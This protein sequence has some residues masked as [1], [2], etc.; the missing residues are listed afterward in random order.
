MTKKI[1]KILI[2]IIISL[3]IGTNITISNTIA[4]TKVLAATTEKILSSKITEDTILENEHIPYLVEDDITIPKNITLTINEGVKLKFAPNTKMNIYGTLIINGSSQSH[5]TFTSQTDEKWDKL[6]INS[7]LNTINYLDINNA[8]DGI[9][10]LNNEQPN[11]ITNI[12]MTN[13]IYNYDF[14]N[15]NYIFFKNSIL[16]AT[17]TLTS[18]YDVNKDNSIDILDISYLANSYNLKSGQNGF[19]QSKDFNKDNIIDIYDLILLSKNVGA[20]SSKLYGYTVFIDPGHG[21]SD[22][23]AVQNGYK[24]KTI[25]LSLAQKLKA[26]LLKYG[27]DVVMS[28][29][30]DIAVSLDDRTTMATNS[31]ADL[32]ISIHHNSSESSSPTGIT[33]YYSTYRPGIEISG[34]YAIYNGKK[35]PYISEGGG[36]FTINYNGKSKWVNYNTEDITVYDSTPSN[37]AIDSKA[38]STLMVNSI[39]SL[40]FKNDGSI[41]SNLR[42]TRWTTMPSILLEAGFISNA[43][44]AAKVTTSSMQQKIAEKTANSIASY[45]ST[46]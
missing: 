30:S 44:E 20:T 41:D 45:Y 21:G 42:V 22:P 28:R 38:L 32:F 43:A 10:I 34:V 39:S 15:D 37:A 16:K 9:E 25:N 36:G 17:S 6:L 13:C 26:E 8:K 40:G 2:P 35:Y 3:L 4:N 1:N 14:P 19:L 29:E 23:G 11:K 7:G 27:A 24:E 5:V 12:Q 31:K 33:T 46:K 18:D